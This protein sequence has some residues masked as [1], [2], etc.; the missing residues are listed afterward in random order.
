MIKLFKMFKNVDLIVVRLF[1][2]YLIILDW[3]YNLVKY[4]IGYNFDCFFNC[5]YWIDIN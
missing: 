1:N 2:W 4:F 3:F 5:G